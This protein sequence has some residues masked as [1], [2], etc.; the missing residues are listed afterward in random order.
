VQI[1]Q[2]SVPRLGLFKPPTTQRVVAPH[3]LLW[4]NVCDINGGTYVF[5][6]INM[7]LTAVNDR[8]GNSSADRF[9]A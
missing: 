1:L 6:W 9:A 2:E 3:I 5:V 7:L 4:K 8:Q